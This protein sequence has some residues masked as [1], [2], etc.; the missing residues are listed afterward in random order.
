MRLKLFSLGGKALLVLGEL[1]FVIAQPVRMLHLDLVGQRHVQ[2]LMGRRAIGIQLL[3]LIMQ[4]ANNVVL[5]ILRR[6]RD[7]LV[8]FLPV[9]VSFLMHFR[10]PLV[11]PPSIVVQVIAARRIA[12]GL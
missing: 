1:P 10:N 9:H 3:H 12:L 7:A 11:H 6:F 8:Q 5:L 4:F 2:L